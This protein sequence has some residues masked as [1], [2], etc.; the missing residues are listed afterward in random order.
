MG[1]TFIVTGCT[2]DVPMAAGRGFQDHAAR[3]IARASV[4]VARLR[5]STGRPARDFLLGTF[6]GADGPYPN[7]SSE[8]RQRN[9][10]VV[11]LVKTQ[12]SK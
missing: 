4:A 8:S 12:E 11:I 6:G 2:D 1:V 10:T 5:A 3:G 7:D 9:R